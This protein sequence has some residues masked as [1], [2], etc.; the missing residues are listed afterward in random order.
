MF[1][2]AFAS[3]EAQPDADLSKDEQRSKERWA[4]SRRHYFYQE[5]AKA[6]C[7]SF[8]AVSNLIVVGF[9]SGVFCLYEL[10]DFI[11]IH[12]LR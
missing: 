12:T 10:P 11:M 5:R 7:A 2:W 3:D 1:E 9:S 8:H 6:K 4:I